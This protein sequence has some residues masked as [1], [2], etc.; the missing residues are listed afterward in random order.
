MKW[1]VS[2]VAYEY[3]SVVVE[4]DSEDEAIEAAKEADMYGD[5]SYHTRDVDIVDI[6]AESYDEEEEE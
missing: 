6:E 5:V 3:G 2:V 4:A 1:R